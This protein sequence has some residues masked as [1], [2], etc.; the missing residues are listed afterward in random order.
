MREDWRQLPQSPL[1]LTIKKLFVSS[2][3][4]H[5]I[6]KLFI[7]FSRSQFFRTDVCLQPSWDTLFSS[8]TLQSLYRASAIRATIWT[9]QEKL[10]DDDPEMN[11]LI[12]KEKDRQV[13]GLELIASEVS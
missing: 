5:T 10:E 6:L 2:Q 11:E 4:P 3:L 13:R 12:K 1:I 7:W 9:G 8:S